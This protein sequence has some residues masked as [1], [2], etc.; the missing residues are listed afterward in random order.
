MHRALV[1]NLEQ[2]GPL[3]IVEVTGEVDAASE[4]VDHTGSAFAALDTVLGVN[5]AMIDLDYNT[6]ERDL[7]SICVHANRH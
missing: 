5:L 4:L 6:I 3:T 1:G 7:L 2:L